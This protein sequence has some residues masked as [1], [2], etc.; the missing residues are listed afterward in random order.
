MRSAVV[1][2]PVEPPHPAEPRYLTPGVPHLIHQLPG[3]QVGPFLVENEPH[4]HAATCGIGERLRKFAWHGPRPIDV[5]REMDRRPAAAD[6][7]EHRRKDLVAVLQ[8]FDLV[9]LDH[10][11]SGGTV[12]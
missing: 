1:L 6:R 9:P 3:H 4:H 5:R 11:L 8:Q 12:Q 7:L 10:A 2:D